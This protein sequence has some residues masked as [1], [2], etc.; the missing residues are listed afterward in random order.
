MQNRSPLGREEGQALIQVTLSIMVLLAFVALAIDV[1]R[2]YAERRNMQNAADA[3]ALAGAREL[4]LD[5]STT[6]AETKAAEI[7][8]A[9]GVAAAA[10]SA[11]DI[12][13][14]GSPD[15]SII[16]VV[17]RHPDLSPVVGQLVAWGTVDVAATASAACG[18][19]TSACGLWPVALSGKAWND[20]NPAGADCEERAIAIWYD[21]IKK[22]DEFDKKTPFCKIDGKEEPNLC[23]CYQCPDNDKDG[24]EDFILLSTAGRGWLDF[25]GLIDPNSVYQDE[26]YGSG[27]GSNA[28]KCQISRNSAFQIGDLPVCVDGLN[29]VR[30]STKV[31]VDDRAGDVVKVPLYD[32]MACNEDS[33]KPS[34]MLSGF[35]CVTVDGWVQLKKDDLVKNNI[36]PK[37]GFEYIDGIELRDISKNEKI[38]LARI[39]CDGG[40]MTTCGTTDG[41]APGDSDLRAVNLIQ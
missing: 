33:S 38:I 23:K 29:G 7:L 22:D 27:G 20:I 14:A 9:N 26:C 17:A 10:I 34:Y 4:C 16:N 31:P 41:T 2:T 3:A 36:E 6:V 12:T 5:R 40:C 13:F 1:G 28:L 8:R 35:A 39:N 30:A 32:S 25:S 11:D 37:P 21:D 15:P 19:A 24:V 18:A